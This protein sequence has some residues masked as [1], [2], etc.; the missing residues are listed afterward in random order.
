MTTTEDRLYAGFVGVLL[1]L[2]L[3]AVVVPGMLILFLKAFLGMLSLVVFYAAVA[4]LYFAFTG[5]SVA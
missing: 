3:F 4:L 5:R 2:L 1:L